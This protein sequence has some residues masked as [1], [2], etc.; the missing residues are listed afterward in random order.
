MGSNGERTQRPNLKLE[1][2]VN[3]DFF[4]KREFKLGTYSMDMFCGMRLSHMH[5]NSA[6]IH[7][8]MDMHSDQ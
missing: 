3:G 8:A 5:F 6:T 1:H 4:E 7:E 2:L